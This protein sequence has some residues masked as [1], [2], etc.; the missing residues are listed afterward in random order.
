MDAIDRSGD[1]PHP[2]DRR[3]FFAGLGALAVGVAARADAQPAPGLDGTWGGARDG[4][5]AQVIVVGAS[6]IGF[7]WRGDYLDTRDATLAADGRSLTFGFK[8]G[9]ARLTR[10]GERTANLDVREGGHA[11]HLDLRRD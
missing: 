2:I 6:V 7:Y 3:L 4:A 9:Q 11:L 5:S 10:T 1:M 8:G